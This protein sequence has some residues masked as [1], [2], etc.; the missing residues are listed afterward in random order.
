MASVLHDCAK[1]FEAYC[2][3]LKKF[4]VITS[5]KILLNFCKYDL[6]EITSW[7]SWTLA[8]SL[9]WHWVQVE[10]QFVVSFIMDWK[11]LLVIVELGIYHDYPNWSKSY[12]QIPILMNYSLKRIFYLV[13]HRLLAQSK[14][15]MWNYWNIWYQKRLPKE[16]RI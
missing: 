13:G 9:L 15:E 8:T 3:F 16:F 12:P 5:C 6:I 1:I 2:R 14:V 4:L 11:R 10:L 7:M